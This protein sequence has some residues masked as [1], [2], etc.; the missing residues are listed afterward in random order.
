MGRDNLVLR[1]AGYLY[2]QVQLSLPPLPHWH[3][4]FVSAMGVHRSKVQNGTIEDAYPAK[5]WPGDSI[6]DHLEFA[7][8]YDG[9]N[10]GILKQ[11]FE[12]VPEVKIVEMIRKKPTGKYARKIW[13]FYE[14]LTTKVL[15]LEN[16]TMGNYVDALEVDLYFTIEKGE[17]SPRHRVVNNLLGPRNFCPIIR[18]T[19]KLIKIDTTIL[20]KK[21][22]DM[23]KAYPKD[24]LKRALNYLYLKETKSSYEI[25]HIKPNPSKTEKFITALEHAERK[26]FFEKKLLVELQNMIVDPRFQ[27]T[28]YRKTQ[29]YIGQTVTYQKELIH[30]I[31][32]KPE[33][34]DN[35]MQGLLDSHFI[36]KKGGVPAI[37]HA[38]AISYGFVFI[39][40]FEDGNGRIHRFLIHNILSTQGL[41]PPGLMFPVSAVMLKNQ[42]DYE[43][44]LEAF[45]RPLMSFIEYNL[46][47]L[48]QLT[49]TNE[50]AFLYQSIDMTTQTEALFSFVT[51][52]IDEEIVE[53][54]N[55]LAKY[56]KTKKAVQE[57]IDMPDR[58]IDLF[59]QVCLQN[60]GKLSSRKKEAH[61]EFLTTAELSAMEQAIKDGYELG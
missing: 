52:T 13:F 53:E 36:M 43:D 23:I 4:S 9:V 2:L 12:V 8:K 40:P 44:S 26:D 54:L 34:I 28:D 46:D 59:I 5:Y 14:F 18:K 31:S 17:K 32:P 48:G 30:Y 55:F 60:N 35:L 1:Q 45:S 58:L 37:I 39:H 20:R 10:L 16:L 42:A 6:Q 51:K 56:D 27:D 57:I 38:A 24:L 49:V 3:C 22:E 15:P 21:C 25:E 61:F 33:N 47:Q 7:L 50:T 41:V 29:N 11:I 19:E